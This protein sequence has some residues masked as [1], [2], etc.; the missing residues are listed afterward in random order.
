MASLSGDVLRGA[1][2]GGGNQEGIANVPSI[3]DYLAQD[4]LKFSMKPGLRA[5]LKVFK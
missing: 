1:H 3:F 2:I 5:A 4:S